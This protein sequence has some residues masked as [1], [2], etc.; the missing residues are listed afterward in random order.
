[1][2]IIDPCKFVYMTS[3]ELANQDISMEIKRVREQSIKES[4]MNEEQHETL[5]KK[6][7]K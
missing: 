1:M 7:H 4:V 5:V 3:E 2:G 6:T